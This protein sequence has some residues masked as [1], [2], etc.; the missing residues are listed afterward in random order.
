MNIHEYQAKTI[1]RK[2]GVATPEGKVAHTPEEAESAAKELG[3][4]VVAVKAQVHAGGRG[5]AGG[6][7]I[8]KSPAEAGAFAGSILGTN[9]VTH[10]TDA[11]G[12]PIHKVYVEA[13]CDIARELYIAVLL[14]RA[15]SKNIIMAS[16]EGGMDIEEVADKH[17]EKIIKETIDPAIGIMPYQA[18]NI[19]F[20]LGLKGDEIKHATKFILGLYKAYLETDAAMLE[21]NPLV[22]TKSGEML[23]LDGKM[24]FDSNALFRHPDIAEMDDPTQQDEREVEAHHWELNYVGLDGNIGC[25]VNGA[26][27]AMATM[28]MIKHYGA[29]PANFLDVGGTATA[30][31][32]TAAFKLILSDPSVKG[33]FV[34]IF[35]GIVK[36]DVI[37]EGIVTAAK[38]VNLDVP[39]VARLRG[40]NMEKGA[41]I[42]ADSGLPIT[43]END[44]AK[45]AQAIVAAVQNAK[46]A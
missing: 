24:N 40:T 3:T 27:L 30:E 32:V 37:A 35:G 17:P 33:L 20:G 11:D 22:V 12:Q 34:N 41:Q 14:D 2:F 7:K 28:D 16:T 46:A 42:L 31:R 8:C 9:L 25:M 4:P 23:A 38:E 6:V 29:E 10:Q 21:I 5:K 26:G 15:S 13:G 45:A 18:R 19:A 44:L 36:C 39:L 43:P 1:L